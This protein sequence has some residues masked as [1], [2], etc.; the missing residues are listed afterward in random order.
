[1]S[2]TKDF[3]IGNLILP[4]NIIYAPLAEY[5]D[6]PYR[7]LVREFHKGLIF[8]EMIKMEALVRKKSLSLLK[9][10][11]EMHPIGAQ[12][13]GSNPNIAADAAKLIE[14]MGFDIID[15]NCGCPSPKLTKDQ[16]GAALL[17]NPKLIQDIVYEMSRAVKIPVTIKIRL[18]WDEN[19]IVAEEIVSLAEEAGAKAITIHARTKKQGYS[20]KARWEFIERCKKKA[21]SILV[22]GNGDLYTP[23]DV[24]EMFK[25]TKCDGVMIARGM[26]SNPWLSE[27]V[28]EYFAQ[29]FEKKDPIFRKVNLIKYIRYI[30]EEKDKEKA[31][32]DIRKISGWYL[33]DVDNIKNLRIKLMGIKDIDLIIKEIEEFVWQ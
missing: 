1:M 26:L 31:Y 2:Y 14:D 16:S 11:N 22:I 19:S 21:K 32:I 17:N 13:V 8:C 30:L 27:Y 23:Q 5:T 29:K 15:L 10:K 33:R 18:G 4:N 12:I 25:Q 3:R 24:D 6:F 20:G 7:K 9:Y 28:E